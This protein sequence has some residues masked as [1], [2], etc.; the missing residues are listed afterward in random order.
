MKTQRI[1][2]R[3]KG[4]EA[5]IQEAIIRFLRE[6]NW[7]VNIT[8]GNMYER[9]FPDLFAAKRRYGPRWI[10]VKNLDKW[11]FTPAQWEFF[12]RFAAE[13]V[14]IWIL[15]AATEEEYVKL[16]EKPNLWKFMGGC[17]K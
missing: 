1:Y 3:A 11:K 9:G 10:E 4:P 17:Y 5:K 8:H 13:G 14:G 15:T 16:F 6:R 7:F 2:N 12:P